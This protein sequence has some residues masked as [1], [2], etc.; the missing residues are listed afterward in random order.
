[1]EAKRME[2][3]KSVGI[4]KDALNAL[5]LRSYEG[6]VRVVRTD[7][8]ASDAVAA[9]RRDRVLGFDTETR[10]SFRRGESHPPALVQLASRNQAAVFQLRFLTLPGPLGDLLG[11]PSVIKAGIALTRDVKEL[12][13]HFALD[14]AGFMEIETMAKGLGIAN[15]GLRGLAGLLL[16]FRISKAARTSNWAADVL[17]PQQVAYAAT[18]AWIGREVYL[19]L[20][21]M[22]KKVG[23]PLP[24]AL[25]FLAEF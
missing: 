7:S 14:A 3:P 18:D 12:Q 6:R 10:P 13:S 11:D 24:P 22:S 9:L 5:P 23:A 19:K 16:G 20:E 4:S 25:S 1:M 15:G 2:V 21:R 8:E 17:T